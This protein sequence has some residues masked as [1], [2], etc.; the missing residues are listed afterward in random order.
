MRPSRLLLAASLTIALLVAL[1]PA[2]VAEKSDRDP[3][4][5]AGLW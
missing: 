3:R 1:A 5:L 4:A 2:A